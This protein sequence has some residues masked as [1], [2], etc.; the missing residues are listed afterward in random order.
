MS[1]EQYPELAAQYKEALEGG[2]EIEFE[3]NGFEYGIEKDENGISVWK[4]A[5][6]AKNGER[7]LT[8]SSVEELFEAK[9]FEGKN[10]FEI[11]DDVS[12]AIVF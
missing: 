8:A 12:N 4:F 7:V 10:I 3:Y 5:K 2:H 1:S 6:G 9:C 11:E